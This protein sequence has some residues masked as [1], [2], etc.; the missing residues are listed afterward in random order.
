M[1]SILPW[2]A[3]EEAGSCLLALEKDG[4]KVESE[5]P[6]QVSILD[7]GGEH[8]FPSTLSFHLTRGSPGG[9]GAL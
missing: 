6:V 1:D 9:T 3:R 4:E 5:V 2:W 8:K 7:P